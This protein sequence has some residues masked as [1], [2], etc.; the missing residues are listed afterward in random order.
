MSTQ[1]LTTKLYIPATRSEMVSRPHLIERLNQGLRSRLSLVCAP[2]GFGKTTIISEWLS[3]CDRSSAWVSL[4]DNDND[5]TRFLMY[6]IAALQTIEPNIG[7]DLLKTL[8]SPQP[9]AID[10]LLIPLINAL[11][12]MPEKVILVLDDYHLLDT[13][14][15]DATLAFLL[16]NI[17]PQMHIVITTREDPQ[18]P[19]ARL[20]ARGFL[21]ELRAKDLR[22]TADESAVFLNQTLDTPLSQDHIIALEK[23]TEGWIAGLQLAALSMQGRADIDSFIQSFTGD[24]RYIVDYLV[25]EVLQHQSAKMQDFLLQTSILERLSPALCAAVTNQSDAKN[26]LEQLE[27]S[28]LFVIYLDDERQWYRYH[29]LFCD[30]LHSHLLKH[31]PDIIPVLH[32]RASDWYAQQGFELDALQHAIAGTHI[33]HAITIIQT[34]Q[35]PIYFRGVAYPILQWLKSLSVDVLN[36]SPFLWVVYAWVLMISYQNAQVEEKLQAAEAVLNQSNDT[37]MLK[38]QIAAIRAM[39]AANQY[40]TEMIIQQSQ[41]ALDL[42]DTNDAYLRAVITRTLAIAYQFQGELD[43]AEATYHEAIALSEQSNNQFVNILAKT[44]LGIIHLSKNHLRLAE[45]TFRDVLDLVGEPPTPIACAAYL[46]LGRIYYEWNDL[47]KAEQY[48]M[49]GIE[50]ARQIDTID[51]ATAGEIF[52][53]KLKLIQGQITE[54]HDT[55]E[56]IAQVIRQRGFEQQVLPLMALKVRLCLQQGDLVEAQRLAEAHNLPL[57]KAQIYL[58]QNKAQDVLDTLHDFQ[59]T[60]EQDWVDAQLNAMVLQALAYQSLEDTEQA[61]QTMQEVLR[62]TRADKFIRLF[63]D[64]GTSMKQLI[65]MLNQRGFMPD[66]TQ[67]LLDAFDTELDVTQIPA[68]QALVEP[69]SERELEILQLVADGLSNREISDKLYLALSTVK[70][71]NRNIY[72]KLGVSRRTEAVALA[73]ELGLISD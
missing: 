9:P 17:P 10:T 25:D 63:V 29:H 59:H 57:S 71:H 42:L 49:K 61:L 46:R 40:Q 62:R 51:S 14:E 54:A 60:E 36:T 12:T 65:H 18:L 68:N 58:A 72:G 1:I 69:L 47:E 20:R 41:L 44:G 16:D 28:N 39:L 48:T 24:H 33:D 50:L 67:T 27:R 11:A 52:L 23:R 15:I 35:V 45:Q 4:D 2:A 70:G 31:Q 5:P 38:G 21:S 37:Q 64:E 7:D 13:Q 55:A 30:V 26:L 32:Q 56:Q 66:Y 3:Q 6:V 19:L 34:P 22:F 53:A 43:L 8:Q 73:R